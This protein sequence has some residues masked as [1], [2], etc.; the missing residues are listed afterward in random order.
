MPSPTCIASAT[1][2]PNTATIATALQYGHV[3]YPG[4]RNCQPIA[5]ANTTKPAN[6]ARQGLNCLTRKSDSAS[7]IAVVA[8]FTAQNPGLTSGTFG[9]AGPPRGEPP[10]PPPP[11]RTREPIPPCAYISS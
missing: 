7:P 4:T 8:I 5:I 10:P 9:T 2:V 6:T 3:R 1:I 11:P